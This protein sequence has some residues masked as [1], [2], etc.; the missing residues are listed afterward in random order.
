VYR[1]RVIGLARFSSKVANFNTPQLYLSPPSGM[2]PFKFLREHWC[3]KTRF[4]GLSCGIICAILCLAVLILGLY[5]S[6]IDTQTDRHTTTAYT[7]LS[8]ASCSKIWVTWRNHASFR[9]G[10]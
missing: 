2:I 4:L 8:I 10:L 9:D 6:V 5:W 7:T 1:F 3:Q